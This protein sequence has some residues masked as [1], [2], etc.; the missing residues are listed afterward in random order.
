M[1]PLF[2]I[3]EET[4]VAEKYESIPDG[5]LFCDHMFPATE[6]SLYYTP[7]SDADYVSR[8]GLSWMRPKVTES[9]CDVRF[10]DPVWRYIDGLVQERRNSSALAMELRLS[11]TNPSIWCYRSC[12]TLVWELAWRQHAIIQTHDLR[13]LYYSSL[14]HDDVIKWKSSSALL[15]LCAGNSPATG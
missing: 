4:R 3:Q 6:E 12:W 13:L 5:G 7:G 2:P 11:C 1:A 14:S 10:I 15:A 9:V 8:G